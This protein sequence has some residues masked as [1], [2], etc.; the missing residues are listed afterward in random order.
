MSVIEAFPDRPL[1]LRVAGTYQYEL[2]RRVFLEAYDFFAVALR[3]YPISIAVAAIAAHPMPIEVELVGV[4]T[5]PRNWVKLTDAER[6]RI[7]NARPPYRR[8]GCAHA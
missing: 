6:A 3:A 1:R 8:A 2:G 4:R 7:L 5:N